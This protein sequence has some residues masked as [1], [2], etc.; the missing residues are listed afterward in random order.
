MGK[1]VVSVTCAACGT[2]Y[3]TMIKKSGK[4]A[5]A[6]PSCGSPDSVKNQKEPD[7]FEE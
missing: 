2:K 3:R 6:C 4:Q 1:A 7:E 5:R